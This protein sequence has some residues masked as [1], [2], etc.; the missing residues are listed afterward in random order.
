MVQIKINYDMAKLIN[1]FLSIILI[2]N[3]GLFF[4]ISQTNINNPLIIVII[5]IVSLILFVIKTI[6]EKWIDDNCNNKIKSEW[7]LN[8]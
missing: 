5:I 8:H 2:I 7:K 1:K 3:F 4:T 6:I